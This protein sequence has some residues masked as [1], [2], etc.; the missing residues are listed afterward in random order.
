MSRRTRLAAMLFLLLPASAAIAQQPSD[1]NRPP[2]LVTKTYVVYDLVVAVPNHRFD[3]S[4]LPTTEQ[5]TANPISPLMDSGAFG[6][7]GGGLGAGMSG[8][9]FN[10]Q[11][12]QEGMGGMGGMGGMVGGM[13][14]MG[15]MGGGM[16]GG[17]GG[18]IGTGGA[19]NPL[20]ISHDDLIQLITS[21]LGR[22]TWDVVGGPGS[23]DV[24]G[25]MLVVR[26]EDAIQKQ[27]GELLDSLRQV[28][29]RGRV[30]TIKAKLLRLT[31][32]QLEE[33]TLPDSPCSVKPEALSKLSVTPTLTYCAQY[34]CLNGQTCFVSLGERY[35][36]VTGGVAVVGG[37]SVGY[38]LQTEY[39]NSGALVQTTSLVLPGGE[40]AIVD[41][42]GVVSAVRES[43]ASPIGDPQLDRIS[44][45][46]A[47][48]A[49]TVRVQ[50]GQPF[51]VGGLTNTQ[52]LAADNPQADQQQFYLVLEVW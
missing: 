26:N 23:I 47:Q 41:V 29:E 42:H 48:L 11:S 51:L 2:Q 7:S 43:E 10:V 6:L 50:V 17:M 5:A 28:A 3:S 27:I 35:T 19:T 16:S 45:G 40:R 25:G 46:T 32:Q 24:V 49:T 44:M 13:G 30:V 34:S 22:D 21:I 52:A 9:M 8:G 33:L 38:Q 31:A 18:M 12:G 4:R 15:G 20:A 14:G 36:A 1:R 39:P 37:A